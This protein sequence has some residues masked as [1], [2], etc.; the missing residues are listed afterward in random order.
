MNTNPRD[1][2]HRPRFTPIPNVLK[3]SET[4]GD[5]TVKPEKKVKLPDEQTEVP[6]TPTG[7]FQGHNINEY[8]RKGYKG[9]ILGKDPNAVQE[10]S[11]KEE[12]PLSFNDAEPKPANRK[13]I[14]GIVKQ[15]P[16]KFKK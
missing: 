14:Q 5:K 6:G 9:R 2:L 4:K 15:F 3:S 16:D 13:I 10:S 12:K 1:P 11:C 8:G 7:D